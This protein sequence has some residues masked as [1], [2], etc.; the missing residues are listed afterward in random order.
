MS[1]PLAA[2]LAFKPMQFSH[3]AA[4]A[5]HMPATNQAVLLLLLLH[6]LP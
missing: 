4:A 1:S 5:T 3:R 2:T 6:S